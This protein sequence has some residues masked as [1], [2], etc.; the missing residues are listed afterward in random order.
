VGAD[1]WANTLST[2]YFSSLGPTT[3]YFDQDNVPLAKPE[4][5]KKPE[6]AAPDGVDTTFFGSPG[7][8]GDPH[9][10][11]FG[12]SAAAPHAAAVGALLIEAAGGPGQLSPDKLK[13]LLEQTTQQPHQLTTAV[14]AT[15]TSGADTLAVKVAGFLPLDPSQFHF[16]FNG[17]AGDSV[18]GI[19]MDASKVNISF[20]A[21]TD[22]FL[23]GNTDV[24]PADI[25]FQNKNGLSPV[26]RLAF[27]HQAFKS[28]AFV[29][30]GFDFDSS[31]VGFLGINSGLLYGTKVTATIDSGGTSTPVSGVL[32][33]PTGLGYAVTDGFGLIDAFVAYKKLIGGA[34]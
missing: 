1:F 7:V 9:P 17:A 33:G 13:T 23:I 18:S 12:T 31:L 30:L 32:G 2:E 5:R 11:F 25:V 4:I 10:L 26:A 3:I 34:P 29:N 28:G 24:P 27:L 6:I 16:A 19:V 20:G 14:S 15:L 8:P 21:R 22:Q